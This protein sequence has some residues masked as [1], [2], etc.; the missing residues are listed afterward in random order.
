VFAEVL[1]S[2]VSALSTAST[3]T[4]G[5]LQAA[6]T[7][8]STGSILSLSEQSRTT[9]GILLI[10][11]V[12]IAYGGTFMLRV[13][14]GSVP[15][16]DFQKAYFRAGH[17]HAGVLVILGLIGTILVDATSLHGFA[18]I[19]ARDGAPL[20]AILISAGFF[21]SAIGSNRTTPNRF[22]VLIWLGALSLSAGVLTLGI[23][24]LTA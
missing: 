7:A 5:S 14:G 3:P 1:V 4:A 20:A 6:S 24:L 15:T 9:A 11:V 10:T 12:G 23:G 2:T 13:V 17:A 22:Q 21:F 8:G 19:V 18:R 16:T